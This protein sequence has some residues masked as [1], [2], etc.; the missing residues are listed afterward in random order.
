MTKESVGS[1]RGLH[2]KRYR[3]PSRR[4]MVPG[5]AR[6]RF[7][8]T[9]EEL[10]EKHP[11][12]YHVTDPGNWEGIQKHGLLSTSSLLSV[13]EVPAAQRAVIDRQRRPE[14]V[15][16]THPV[17]GEVIINDNSSLSEKALISCLDDGLAPTDWYAMLNKRVFFWVDKKPLDKFLKAQAHQCWERLVLELSTSRV[18]KRNKERMELSPINSGSTIYQPARRGRSTF[19]LLLRHDYPTW[20]RLRNK[21]TPDRI[22]EVTVVGGVDPITDLVIERH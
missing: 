7:A 9:P 1:K 16:L 17:H 6:T 8:V 3:F 10:A 20:Q 4:R 22:V 21:A 15:R 18:A 14:S 19:T 13:F 11:R 2:C 12:L 5:R